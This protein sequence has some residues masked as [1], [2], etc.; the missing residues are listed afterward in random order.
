MTIHIAER[1]IAFCGKVDKLYH[2]KND[3]FIR[4]TESMMKS[5]L[6][7]KEHVR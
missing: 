3:N 7:I 2:Q 4:Q 6:V 5:D 1:N